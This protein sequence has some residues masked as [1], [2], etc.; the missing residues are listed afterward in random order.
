MIGAAAAAGSKRVN[1]YADEGPP[2]AVPNSAKDWLTRAHEKVKNKDDSPFQI[3]EVAALVHVLVEREF[4]CDAHIAQV[5]FRGLMNYEELAVFSELFN[6]YTE[7]R[8][9]EAAQTGETYQSCLDIFDWEFEDASDAEINAAFG[10]IKVDRLRVHSSDPKDA[11][12]P[13]RRLRCE[14]L[15]VAALLRGGVTQV[16]FQ[17]FNQDADVIAQAFVDS[18][19]ESFEVDKDFQSYMASESE[20]VNFEKLLRGLSTCSTLTSLTFAHELDVANAILENFGPGKSPKLTSLKLTVCPME[21]RQESD[22]DEGMVNDAQEVRNALQATQAASVRVVGTPQLMKTIAGLSSLEVLKIRLYGDNIHMDS[23]NCLEPLKHHRSLREFRLDDASQR[24]RTAHPKLLPHAISFAASCPQLT[25]LEWSLPGIGNALAAATDFLLEGGFLDDGSD[26]AA[27]VVDLASMALRLQI[28]K[29]KNVVLSPAVLQGFIQGLA[30][31]RSLLKLDIR[32]CA[33]ELGALL[34]ILEALSTNLTIE[35]ILLPQ[36]ASSYYMRAA[37]RRLWGLEEPGDNHFELKRGEATAGGGVSVSDELGMHRF[38][39]LKERAKALKAALPR[40]LAANRMEVAVRELAPSLT[41]I[42]LAG[43]KEWVPKLVSGSDVFAYVA[44]FATE[45]LIQQRAT[46]PA[47]HWT[48]V[49]TS[50]DARG[51]RAPAQP[52]PEPNNHVKKLVQQDRDQPKAFRI[53]VDAIRGWNVYWLREHQDAIAKLDD[54][55]VLKKIAFASGE[56]KVVDLFRAIGVDPDDAD[57]GVTNPD[58]AAVAYAAACAQVDVERA[59]FIPRYG[60]SADLKGKVW[61]LYASGAKAIR[62]GSIT[63]LKRLI[64]EGLP[65]NVLDGGRFNALLMQASE[66]KRLNM[67]RL[68]RSSGAIDFDEA[69][70]GAAPESVRAAIDAWDEEQARQKLVDDA[71]IC[72]HARDESGVVALIEAGLPL[73]EMDAKGGNK[74]LQ[75]A[76]KSGSLGIVR[77]LVNENASD[78]FGHALRIA[79]DDGFEAAAVELAD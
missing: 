65:L 74:L 62:N 30:L 11:S 53:V 17:N 67:L 16:V 28:L 52:A 15:C 51:Q 19:L 39:Q 61:E 35:D 55:D 27:M 73:D 25:H 57:A 58:G 2:G 77:L 76:V 40:R 78:F 47:V 1:P 4:N 8:T 72:I 10:A 9:E 29:L 22:D 7:F 34:D 68:L 18:R 42:L 56:P 49:L 64:V 24:S 21:I 69:V 66:L 3:Q 32:D 48:E 60:Y 6:R 5:A 36:Y 43:A 71:L 23:A 59:Q 70:K 54:L 63:T 41:A 31:N 44:N 50:A 38:A 75:A 46:A 37:D 26:I 12:N 14:G 45:R 13:E 79:V 33:L 20:M